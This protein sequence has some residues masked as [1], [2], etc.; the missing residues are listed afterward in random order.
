[1]L[2]RKPGWRPEFSVVDGQ[3]V[4]YAWIDDREPVGFDAAKIAAASA[5][6]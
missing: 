6:R 2:V 3:Q 4:D 1:M 5:G